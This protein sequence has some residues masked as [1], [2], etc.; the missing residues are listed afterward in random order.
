MLQSGALRV[1]ECFYDKGILGFAELCKQAEYP[2]DL[3]G[4]YIRQ[5]VNGG[6]LEKFERGQYV[7]LPK[8]KQEL[9]L[10]SYRRTLTPRPRLGVALVVKQQQTFIV[11]HRKVQPFV[12]TAEWP[13]GMARGGEKIASA[14]Q[15]LMQERLGQDVKP[16]LAGFF[17]RIDMH[18]DMVFD[19]KIFA[20]HTCELPNLAVIDKETLK[21]RYA[22]YT[23]QEIKKL[24]RPSRSLLDIFSYV[25][26]G[27]GFYE[28]H[29]YVL[30]SDDLDLPRV[31]NSDMPEPFQAEVH[32]AG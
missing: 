7:L 8:G 18:K 24:T 3:G 13:A 5:L 32:N 28:E 6:Y 26:A 9:A 16:T 19:D 14:A 25:E 11:M 10:K 20:V 12:N 22:G 31:I 21:G 15:R 30:T 1:L 27:S 17:R 29:I 23:S 4:Y 2:T